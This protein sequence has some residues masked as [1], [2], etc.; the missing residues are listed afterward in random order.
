VSVRI[1]SHRIGSEAISGTFTYGYPT[2]SITAP[3][4]E[5][6]TNPVTVS[7]TYSSVAG[8]AQQKFRVKLWSQDQIILLQSTE[9][10]SAATSTTIEYTFSTFSE[11]DITV[12]V[13]DGMNWS[14]PAL[15]TSI[16]VGG[17]IV[18]DPNTKVGSVYE[19]GINGVGYM[20]RDHPDG[21]WKYERR[22]ASIE[23]PRLATGDTPFSEGFDRYAMIGQV[24]WSSG[25]GQR[26]RDRERSD[27][28][29]YWRSTGI[30]PFEVGELSLLTGVT[31]VVADNYSPALATVYGTNLIQASASAELKS[32]TTG[33]STTTFTVT[34]LGTPL[35]CT[36]DGTYWYYCNG[37]N[38]YRNNAAVD[39]GV[40]WSTLDARVIEWCGDRI[41]VAYPS[42]GSTP[43][44]VAVLTDAGAE[45]GAPQK[46]TLPVG[47]TVHSITS[48]GGYIWW[49]AQRGESSW[50]YAWQVGSPD[51]Y[52]TALD[53]PT[54]SVAQGIFHY[55]GI[56]YIQ[57]A[58]S[59]GT[60]VI[61]RAAVTDGG[62]LVPSV[63]VDLEQA[64][65]IP[66]PFV[67]DGDKVLFGYTNMETSVSG[68]GAIDLASGGWTKWLVSASGGEVR[69]VV[70]WQGVAAFTLDGVGSFKENATV[71][72]SGQIDMSIADL[73]TG[74]RK[75]IDT[76]TITTDPLP[77]GG[78]VAIHVSLDGGLSY[79]LLGTSDADGSTTATFRID[80][81]A[82]SVA[83]RLVLAASSTSPVVRT[84]SA[85]THPI[86]L[87]DRLLVLPINCCD[88]VA[89]LNGSPLPDQQG[90]GSG[91][92]RA[93]T[94]EA[95]SQQRVYV[96]DV[97]WAATDQV[98]AYEVVSV[99]VQSV[100]VFQP[101][102]NRQI[103][104]MTAVV[105]LRGQL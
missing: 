80:R 7:W 19:V 84:I 36:S 24:D 61:Y 104:D 83:F 8:Y 17:A 62:L 105:T 59:D 23:A 38:A 92:A 22:I 85:K 3:G 42:S 2:V 99:E 100:G 60:T 98:G 82:D 37:S 68:V 41:V 26:L 91:A 57:A 45:V 27:R 25:A 87:H 53:M 48:G 31:A 94:L 58:V 86:G 43:N 4:S 63:L 54:G 10:S 66:M 69:S 96:Q 71:R 46:W 72:S 28:N 12:E 88:S 18:P 30:D 14:S 13:F 44:V 11:Y 33:G 6:S 90:V 49:S 74:L 79:Q 55:Q 32:T 1:G 95:L 101:N 34:G 35:D 73:G 81:P 97:D 78:S 103:Q 93:R 76:V 5:F 20:L 51:S 65:T 39:P 50:I 64:S 77:T 52:I 75:Q 9:V 70:V 15:V 29:A 21:K 47:T 16:Y 89:G 56:V 102:V 40:A 67:G